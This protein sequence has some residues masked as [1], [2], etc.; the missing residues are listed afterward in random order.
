MTWLLIVLFIFF[1]IVIFAAIAK[2]QSGNADGFPYQKSKSLFSPAERSFLGV[3]EQ[4][5]GSEHRVFGK[6]RIADVASVKS[7]GNRSTWQRAFNRIS[8]KHFDF[9]IC[10]AS[11]LSVVCAV[12]LDDKSHQQGKRKERDN[13]VSGVCQAISLPLLQISAQQAYSLQELQ[14]KVSLAINPSPP[15]AVVT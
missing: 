14:T 12:E 15:P 6:V 8:A 2:Q 1:T 7:S 11:D 4:A 5:V 9:V 13:F 10:K 3:L